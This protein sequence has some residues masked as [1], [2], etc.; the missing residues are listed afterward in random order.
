[1][2]QL[3]F[4]PYVTY[5][6]DNFLWQEGVEYKKQSNML[7]DYIFIKLNMIK[8]RMHARPQ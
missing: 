4:N 1:M 2:I 3:F 6:C 8:G 7:Y 5:N